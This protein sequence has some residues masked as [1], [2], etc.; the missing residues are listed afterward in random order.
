MKTKLWMIAAAAAGMLLIFGIYSATRP[1]SIL[2][3]PE[4]A[5][6]RIEDAAARFSAAIENGRDVTPLGQDIKPV[7]EQHPRLRV[8]RVLLGQWYL[9]TGERESAY[10]QFAAALEL[11]P[12]DA[13]L[14]NLAGT[15]ALLIDE[16][17]LAEGHYRLAAQVD[18]ED[19]RWLL[20]L[21]DV[22][23]KAERW[24][25]A[26]LVLIEV[27]RLDV[28]RHEAHAGLADVYARRGQDGDLQRAIDQME[29]ARA[30]VIG[31]PEAMETQ[32]VYVRKLARLYARQG[33]AMEAARVLNTL[34]P[35]DARRRPAVIA[36][37]AGYLAQNG[38][39]LAAALEYQLALQDEPDNAEFAAQGARW[40]IAAE[41]PDAARDLLE[42]LRLIDPAHPAIA[43]LEAQLAV[44]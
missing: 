9:E 5:Q 7:V 24:D 38:Q 36:E 31:D 22:M 23:I 14:Q 35:D 40:L 3:T 8:G 32:I 37:L 30:Q 2:M 39:P 4:Q 34:L 28:T 41:R 10:E 19:P 12:D 13:P 16:P 25:E 6:A 18:P 44:E 43:K 20:P 21:A 33:D 1:T 27:L 15:T 26:R 42:R 29:K 11:D 17:T